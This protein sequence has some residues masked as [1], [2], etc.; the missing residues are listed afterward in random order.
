MVTECSQ[1]N[2]VKL[3]MR[4]R[5]LRIGVKRQGDLRAEKAQNK[6]E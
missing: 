2:G 3:K 4:E 1:P 6:R 5:K